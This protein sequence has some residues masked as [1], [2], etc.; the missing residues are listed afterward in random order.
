MERQ[1]VVPMDVCANTGK[2]IR[3][4]QQLL[5]DLKQLLGKEKHQLITRKELA[6]YLGIDEAA[7]KLNQ[8]PPGSTR[9]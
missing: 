3:H 5:K 2:K 4:A 8:L 1:F 6:D 7:L 9:I